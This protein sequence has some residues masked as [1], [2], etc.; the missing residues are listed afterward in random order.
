MSEFKV[1]DE[2]E[3]PVNR[4]SVPQADLDVKD[5]VVD[6]SDVPNEQRTQ[7]EAELRNVP[8]LEESGEASVDV[9]D[10]PV[11]D[12]SQH[13]DRHAALVAEQAAIEASLVQESV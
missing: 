4:V 9:V 3:G 8:V 13:P 2:V 7:V 5:G 11:S 6:L 10:L 1:R 12:T